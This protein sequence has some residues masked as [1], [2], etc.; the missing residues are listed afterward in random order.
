M[1]IVETRKD[2]E[3]NEVEYPDMPIRGIIPGT[4][5]SKIPRLEN[6][7]TSESWMRARPEIQI[8]SK[9]GVTRLKS[10]V[11][12]LDFNSKWING[13]DGWYYYMF[14][15]TPG[16]STE[17]L[18]T[19]VSF[20]KDMDEEYSDADIEIEVI[21]ESVQTKNNAIDSGDILK[22]RGWPSDTP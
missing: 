12:T 21:G 16:D 4:V 9:D 3:G 18:F 22:A 17:P 7:G 5:V 2:A 15:V 1:K 8:L 13:M 11:I 6:T 10:S 19:E 20:S 14:P